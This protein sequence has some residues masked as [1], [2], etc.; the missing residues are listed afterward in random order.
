MRLE[1]RSASGIF[2]AIA[3]GT[4]ELLQFFGLTSAPIN[5]GDHRLPVLQR[6]QSSEKDEQNPDRGESSIDKEVSPNERPST[7]REKMMGK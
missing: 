4:W 3:F 5:S 7:L 2:G 6:V 1:L